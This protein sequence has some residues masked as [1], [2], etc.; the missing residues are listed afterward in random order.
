MATS[1]PPNRPGSTT[2]AM[3]D[4]LYTRSFRPARAATLLA[5]EKG[6]RPQMKSS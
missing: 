1:K 2:S 5:V 4:P 3:A 6:N